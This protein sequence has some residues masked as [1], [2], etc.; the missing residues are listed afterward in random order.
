MGHLIAF[1]LRIEL[2]N[3]M[4]HLWK[5][6]T[7]SCLAHLTKKCSQLTDRGFQL[8]MRSLWLRRKP[9]MKPP[10]IH[11]SVTKHISQWLSRGFLPEFPGR[12]VTLSHSA[13]SFRRQPRQRPWIKDGSTGA[14]TED[15][16][17][18]RLDLFP[19]LHWMIQTFD[20]LHD[21]EVRLGVEVETGASQR[22]GRL[23]FGSP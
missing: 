18:G 13:A 3:K 23:Y 6:F 8:T 21:F 19:D 7:F 16:E 12:Q 5:K 17:I 1:S 22:P 11:S 20:F 4:N 10:D 2:S 9:D 14:A 15:P